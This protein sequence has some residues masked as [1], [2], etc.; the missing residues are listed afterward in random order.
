MDNGCSV[1]KLLHDIQSDRLDL[2]HLRRL[3][4]PL[5]GGS[6]GS[7]SV[8]QLL[9]DFLTNRIAMGHPIELLQ[10]DNSDM[11]FGEWMHQALDDGQSLADK[12]KIS[13][14]NDGDYASRSGMFTKEVYF[15]LKPNRT[16]S[17]RVYRAF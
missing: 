9:Y 8:Q 4:L 11:P 17:T 16:Y 2:F 14:F 5:L 1:V 15:C 12:V 10:L 3:A 13:A 6:L 7:H